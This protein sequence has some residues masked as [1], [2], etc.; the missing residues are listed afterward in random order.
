MKENDADLDC[1]ARNGLTPIHLAA[2]TGAQNVVKFLLEEGCQFGDT[3]SGCSVLHV[4]AHHGHEDV[5][6][7]LLAVTVKNLNIIQILS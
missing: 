7:V 3:R 1:Q 6:R 2:Q 4:A 5:V